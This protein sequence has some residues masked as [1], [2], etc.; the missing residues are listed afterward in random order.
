ML[1]H[2]RDLNNI[3]ISVAF[4]LP[5]PTSIPR[6]TKKAWMLRNRP[7]LQAEASWDF[8]LLCIQQ[9][10]WS[11][12]M[13]MTRDPRPHHP[14]RSAWQMQWCQQRHRMP[15]DQAQCQGQGLLSSPLNSPAAE[16][17]DRLARD[18]EAALPP[19]IRARPPWVQGTRVQPCQ[20][21]MGSLRDIATSRKLV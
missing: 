4:H 13:R 21:S 10:T 2:R 3:C 7:A 20:G 11:L 12:K 1:L 18:W 19:C 9:Q 8:P 5:G 17:T 6:L 16:G 15:R 14:T